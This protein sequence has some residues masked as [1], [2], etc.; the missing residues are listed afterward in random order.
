MDG[1]P[2]RARTPKV[3]RHAPP[4][5]LSNGCAAAGMTGATPRVADRGC[6]APAGCG[7]RC[8]ALRQTL[9]NHRDSVSRAQLGRSG[10]RYVITFLTCVKRQAVFCPGAASRRPPWRPASGQR[11]VARQPEVRQ[12]L[13]DWL[14]RSLLQSLSRH[15]RSRRRR[16][17][18]AWSCYDPPT[19]RLYRDNRTGT[20]VG[21]ALVRLKP[22]L[23]DVRARGSVGWTSAAQSTGGGVGFGG[24]RSRLSTEGPE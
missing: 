24:Q 20:P 2:Q 19:S 22:R 4:A 10:V 23:C 7:D 9:P 3:T 6:C 15:A 1:T 18:P 12:H 17:R 11:M 14:P 16:Q 5:L 8:T 21:A 13:A